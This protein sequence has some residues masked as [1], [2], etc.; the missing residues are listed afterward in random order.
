MKNHEVQL[1]TGK[2]GAPKEQG[3]KGMRSNRQSVRSKATRGP[4]GATVRSKRHRGK[5]WGQSESGVW[6]EGQEKDESRKQVQGRGRMLQ[7]RRHAAKNSFWW[8][9]AAQ[10]GTKARKLTMSEGN[11]CRYA[12]TGAN[13]YMG[14]DGECRDIELYFQRAQLFGVCHGEWT[15]KGQGY[16]K[17]PKDSHPHRH[18]SWKRK[19]CNTPSAVRVNWT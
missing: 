13:G 8:P 7:H 17:L 18:L 16:A 12:T 5:V 1:E 15:V 11:A 2:G 9:V 4:S 14:T 3:G 6:S 10:G 19:A